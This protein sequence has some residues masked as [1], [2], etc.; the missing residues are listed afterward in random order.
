MSAPGDLVDADVDQIRQ[1]VRVELLGGDPG[2]HG[3]D[4]APGDSA[5]HRHGGLVTLGGQPHRQVLEVA[6]EPRSGAGEV[7]GLRQHPALRAVQSP[8]PQGEHTD[9]SAQVQVPPRRIDVAGVVAVA[10]RIVAVWAPHPVAFRTH[11]DPYPVID[12]LDV[13]D[14]GVRQAQQSGE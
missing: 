14:G 5:E 10:G 4:G 9:A 2:A 6:G 8:A 11:R 7:D 3:A 12:D 13:A 1:P